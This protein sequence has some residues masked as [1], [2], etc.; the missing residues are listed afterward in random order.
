MLNHVERRLTNHQFGFL[1]SRSTLQ[2]LLIFTNEILEAKTEVDVVYMNFRKA[3]NSV[4]HNSLFKKLNSIGITGKLWLWL[5]EYL[6][7]RFQCV[8]IGD[9]MSNLCKVLSGVPQGSVIGPLLLSYS[10]MTSPNVL[11]LQYL[12]FLLMIQSDYNRS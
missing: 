11:S 3:F 8:R 9:S 1:P 6:Q 2:Q 4:S 12:S 10:S 5:R 7:Q